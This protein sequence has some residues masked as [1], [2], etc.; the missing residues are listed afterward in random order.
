MFTTITEYSSTL[1]QA[2]VDSLP[3]SIILAALV[4][5]V[6]R[7]TNW[8]NARARY[9]V[10]WTVLATIVTMPGLILGWTT[11][12]EWRATNVP[13]A[14]AMHQLERH[15]QSYEYDAPGTLISYRV[16]DVGRQTV[17]AQ[18][19]QPAREQ[20][21]L[22]T[23]IGPS[24]AGVQ[25]AAGERS[26]SDLLFSLMPISIA[27]LWLIVSVWFLVGLAVS[28]HHLRVILGDSK[29]APDYLANRLHRWVSLTGCR[30]R[31]SVRTS[32]RLTSPAATGFHRGTVLLPEA[33]VGHL[34]SEELD[35]ILLHELAHLIRRDDWSRLF[36]QVLLAL[37]FFNPAVHWL[38]RQLDL[39]REI[40]CDDAVVARLQ[41]PAAYARTLAK[42]ASVDDGRTRLA[43]S[44]GAV[45]TKKHIFARFA[46]ILN[47]KRRVTT[48]LPKVS[49][50]LTILTIFATGALL[51]QTPSVLAVP[52]ATV[53]FDDLVDHFTPPTEPEPSEQEFDVSTTEQPVVF[54]EQDW[55]EVFAAAVEAD[56][57]P[58]D[59]PDRDRAPRSVPSVPAAPSVPSVP[60]VP[61][62]PSVPSVPAV[63]GVPAAPTVA[64]RSGGG[65]GD[66]VEWFSGG[67]SHSIS[68]T[69]EDDGTTRIAIKEDGHKIK[70]EYVGEIEFTDD[71][72]GIKSIAAGGYLEL[73]ERVSGDR[74]RL[75]IEPTRDGL[76]YAYFEDGRSA[77]YDDEAKDWA[78]DLLIR[79]IRSTGL[80]AEA[81]VRRIRQDKGI[82]GV[83]DEIQMIRS[84]Y[85]KR[86]YVDALLESGPISDDEAADL[87]HIV[88]RDI[89]SDYDKAE[90]L[91]RLADEGYSGDKYT[92]AYADAVAT[93]DSDY[94]TRRVLSAS[95]LQDDL[96]PKVVEELLMMADRMD[97]DYEKAE[98]LIDMAPKIDQDSDHLRAF[99]EALRGIDSDYE[100]R[101]TLD[102][103]ALRRTL[104][105]DMAELL[106]E[107]AFDMDS[108]Y[109]KAELLI[110]LADAWDGDDNLMEL[111]LEAAAGITS[112]Y[113]R[114]RALT[115]L[116]LGSGGSKS[117]KIYQRAIEAT[118]AMSSDYDKAEYLRTLAAYCAEDKEL[119]L[120]YLEA[121]QSISSDYDMKRTMVEVLDYGKDDPE[122]LRAALRAASRISS[123]Y[124]RA[125]VLDELTDAI[126]KHDELEDEYI[127]LIEEMSDYE[128][129]RLY[130]SYYR[131]RRD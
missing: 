59:R 123:D 57:E 98:L 1:L 22:R 78:G 71:D 100:T 48:G 65:F 3:P 25:Q 95:L 76:D 88:E 70:I 130:R 93:I 24:A 31:V 4:G 17:V 113:D 96:D 81:R 15:A 105:P 6:F 125:Q 90:V 33:L 89:D 68:T 117:A 47:N 64:M 56:P 14:A 106:L 2:V 110:S 92:A 87:L 9:V 121:C 12:Q 101:R 21:D 18:T 118:A 75:L 19:D 84:D 29:P 112:D 61:A 50:A 13:S 72:R 30:R 54:S 58:E 80:G 129:D 28:Y 20:P 43:L 102:A 23:E 66:L 8:L 52:R 27:A 127:R 67:G 45:L 63:P 119:R 108:D 114:R 107:I 16:G 91:I 37:T 44:P 94:D 111:Y 35:S 85:V 11:F 131:S 126:A 109:E 122:F 79:A 46:M 32:A 83:L 26:I 97:S 7:F 41:E 115:E 86:V 36:E 51:I 116:N 49:L 99:F 74:R 55:D 34:S 62:T 82:E 69:R 53:S 38:I 120:Q 60:S 73:E 39:N 42:L 77:E 103:L 124:E 104:E 40:A 5:V 128:R 10:L